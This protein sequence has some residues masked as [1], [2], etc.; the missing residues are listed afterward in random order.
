VFSLEKERGLGEWQNLVA[1]V[2]HARGLSDQDALPIACDMIDARTAE[3]VEYEAALLAG[4]G[5]EPVRRYVDG[6][7]SWI[8]GNLDWSRRTH[9]YRE[10][11][12]GE[13]PSRYL[14]PSLMGEAT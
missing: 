14:E 8:R 2:G 13:Q 12:S 6:M 5:G 9:R 11:W 10:G 4:F 1:V 7:R 3:Y